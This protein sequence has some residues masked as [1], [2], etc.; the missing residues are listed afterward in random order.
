MKVSSNE[1]GYVLVIVLMLIMII[2]IFAMV[3]IPKAISSM[4][5]IGI[6]EGTTQTKQMAEMGVEYAEAFLQ[7]QV[8]QTILEVKEITQT[9][10]T[11]NHDT[12]Y[13]EKLT[14][15]LN[16]TTL[17]KDISMKDNQN[18]S[19]QIKYAGA[20]TIVSKDNTSCTGFTSMTVP[21]QSTGKVEGKG[22][23][24]LN[25][26]FVI[27]NKG[28]ILSTQPI[29]TTPVDPNTLAV[30]P[31][32][33][34]VDLSG[35]DVSEL[36]RSAKFIN[37]IMIRGNGRLLI[38][39]NAWL[40]GSPDSIE[41]K[42]SNGMLIISGNAYFTNKVKMS[43]SGANY[44]C[45]KGNAYLYN[46][47]TNKWDPYAAVKEAGACPNTPDVQTRVEYFYDYNEWEI[48]DNKLDVQY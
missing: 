1:R 27:N 7:N 34:I 14:G 10:K 25:A 11:V 46:A 4:K 33:S 43:G 3:L 36:Y 9:N 26:K 19:F 31:V 28:Q 35:K 5:Q 24:Q 48:D 17:L 41:F 32:F 30:D 21:V 15:R 38:G 23:R 37:K 6:S 16:S 47:A 42:G 29:S 45:I 12:L 40:A 39:G 22:T 44:I 20:R 13:C 8:N 2:T 18:Y